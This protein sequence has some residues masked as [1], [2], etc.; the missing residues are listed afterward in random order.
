MNHKRVK[1]GV[2]I[3]LIGIF[4]AVTSYMYN[5]QLDYHLDEERNSYAYGLID[6][7]WYV[8]GIGIFIFIIGISYTVF[9][10]ISVGEINKPSKNQENIHN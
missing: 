2:I 10:L 9:S 1:I 7:N 4:F 5:Q 3:A 8:I 6:L